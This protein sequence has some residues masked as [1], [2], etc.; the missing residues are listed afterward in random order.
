MTTVMSRIAATTVVLA[1]IGIASDAGADHAPDKLFSGK[2]RGAIESMQPTPEGVVVTITARG[3]ATRLGRFSRAEMLLLDP[4]TGAFTGEV[5]F[6]TVRGHRLTAEVA[7][8]F[9][10]PTTATGTYK[11]TGGTGPFAGATGTARFIVESPTGVDFTV[12]FLGNL[13]LSTPR[14]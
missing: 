8:A 14:P 13:D 6:T 1:L 9:V 12:V 3:T 10:T 2:G 5:I 7:G 11:F 4:A